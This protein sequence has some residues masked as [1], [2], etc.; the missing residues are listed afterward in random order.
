MTRRDV[1][2][3]C[4][5]TPQKTLRENAQRYRFWGLLGFPPRSVGGEPGQDGRDSAALRLV[6]NRAEFGGVGRNP[7][8]GCQENYF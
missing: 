8:A 3:L 7:V 1:G 6:R 5:F 2:M 4:I